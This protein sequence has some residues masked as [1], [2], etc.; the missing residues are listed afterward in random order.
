MRRGAIGYVSN[1]FGV[2][3]TLGGG[4]GSTV[5]ILCLFIAL[6]VQ[7]IKSSYNGWSSE[8]DPGYEKI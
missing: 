4:E 5:K 7:F 2:P 3:R 1:R 8:I 6:R